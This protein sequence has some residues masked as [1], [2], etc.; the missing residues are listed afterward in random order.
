[1]TGLFFLEFWVTPMQK[2]DKEAAAPLFVFTFSFPQN[3]PMKYLIFPVLIGL[4]LV[5]CS[6]AKED[7]SI[8]EQQ[9]SV[10]PALTDSVVAPN[11]T[12]TPAPEATQSTPQRPVEHTVVYEG[13][14]NLAVNNFEKASPK[15]D[16]LISL[17]GAYLATAHETRSDGLVR[18]DMTIKV[19]P[20]KFVQ[21][22]SALGKLGYIE[23]KDVASTDVTADILAAANTLATQQAAQRKYQQLLAKTTNPADVQHLAGQERRTKE[24]I[25]TAQA[26]LQ[27]FGAQRKWATLTLHVHQLLP[28]P[29]P[30]E[31]L[32]AFAPQFLEAF[33]RGWSAVL[34]ILVLVTNLWP[35]LLVGAAGALSLRW[36]RLRHPT[37]V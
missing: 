6:Q 15:I 31:Q 7:T 34:G 28:S 16:S 21:L 8:A 25:A 3:L 37:Q 35:L 20:T 18:Q 24:D 36:W 33:N 14:L 12:G 27:Q 2:S 5:G 26:Q 1:L 13:K 29:E 9:A 22:V 23:N 17:H 10:A 19:P 32:P 4:G 11:A 30:T